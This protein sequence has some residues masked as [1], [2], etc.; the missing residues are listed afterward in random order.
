MD[1]IDALHM[2][3]MKHLLLQTPESWKVMCGANS[4]AMLS[5]RSHP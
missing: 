3:F 1:R 5:V 4:I 2:D